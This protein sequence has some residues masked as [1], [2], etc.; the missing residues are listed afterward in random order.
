M[1]EAKAENFF[2]DFIAPNQES[3]KSYSEKLTKLN[4]ERQAWESSGATAMILAEFLQVQSQIMQASSSSHKQWGGVNEDSAR[5]IGAQISRD[6]YHTPTQKPITPIVPEKRFSQLPA[7]TQK[8][9][10]RV[11]ELQAMRKADFHASVSELAGQ[12]SSSEQSL[13]AKWKTYL[14]L[15]L[16]RLISFRSYLEE[17]NIAV[18]KAEQHPFISAIRRNTLFVD[19]KFFDRLRRSLSKQLL[20]DLPKDLFIQYIDYLKSLSAVKGFTQPPLDWL[21]LLA[22]PDILNDS[23]ISLILEKIK[24]SKNLPDLLKQSF[25][26]YGEQQITNE[27]TLV[28]QNL[29]K[30]EKD[31]DTPIS[32][33]LST[34]NNGKRKKPKSVDIPKTTP[35]GETAKP[36]FSLF[37]P[38]SRPEVDSGD[39]R[40]YIAA[41]INSARNNQNLLKDLLSMVE[42]ISGDPKGLGVRRLKG[43]HDVLSD[44]LSRKYPSYR[45]SPLRH[46]LVT[47]Y[48]PDSSRWR[49]VYHLEPN[50][51]E[52]LISLDDILHHED[53]DAKYAL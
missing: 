46:P 1:F 8:N 3:L 42:I 37:L 45:F 33:D 20:E 39:L 50:T 2:N 15:G 14:H 6:L 5:K 47:S 25:S 52:I 17:P 35:V 48:D 18:I 30:W 34:K 13:I 26:S 29:Y 4:E 53:F 32:I 16:D 36:N 19:D 12:V 27:V 44:D 43:R 21:T 38:K 9:L 7:Q 10:A 31:E 22:N 24:Q 40:L 41:T 23:S 49:I 51:D 28:R 11:M